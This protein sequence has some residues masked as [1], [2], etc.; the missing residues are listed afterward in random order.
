MESVGRRSLGFEFGGLE[1]CGAALFI[2]H[3]VHRGGHKGSRLASEFVPTLRRGQRS[4]DD[5]CIR[6]SDGAGTVCIVE[7]VDQCKR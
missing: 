6:A 3:D 2:R 4:T 7:G 5:G 1:V